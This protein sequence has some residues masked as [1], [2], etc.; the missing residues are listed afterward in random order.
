MKPEMATKILEPIL[1]DL[2]R[3]NIGSLLPGS[4]Q[5]KE[6]V[7]KIGNMKIAIYTNDHNPPHFHVYSNDG[8]IDVKFR[9]DNCKLLGGNINST[10]L[11][12]V[13]AFYKHPKTVYIMEQ[14]WNKRN[15]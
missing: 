7:A 11:K 13:R 12:K 14:M 4:L 5:T 8:I 3:D 10:N 1:N 2:F 15:Y 6:Q 9:I